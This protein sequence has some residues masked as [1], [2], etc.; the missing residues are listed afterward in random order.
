MIS[1]LKRQVNLVSREIDER[2]K[3]PPALP[4]SPSTFTFDEAPLNPLDEIEPN[5]LVECLQAN[6]ETLVSSMTEKIAAAEHLDSTFH[7]I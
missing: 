2:T 6:L 7:H 1:D 5:T 4:D 3:L